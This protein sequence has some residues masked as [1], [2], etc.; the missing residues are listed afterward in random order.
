MVGV[1]VVEMQNEM[2]HLFKNRMDFWIQEKRLKKKNCYA[3]SDIPL[4]E[5]NFR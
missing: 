1:S 2:A 3:S 5:K 4:Q